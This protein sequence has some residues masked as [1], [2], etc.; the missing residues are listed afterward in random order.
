MSRGTLHELERRLVAAQNEQSHLLDRRYRSTSD[1]Q[2]LEALREVIL[3][4]NDKI[5]Y[6]LAQM[7]LIE[8]EP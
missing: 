8:D 4:L 6:E 1:E 5:N 2:K 7:P 3:T